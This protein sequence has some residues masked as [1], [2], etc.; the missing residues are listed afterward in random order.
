MPR[1]SSGGAGRRPAVSSLLLALVALAAIPLVALDPRNV[2]RGEP[3]G[4]FVL[5]DIHG[6]RV[7]TSDWEG[8]PAV[9]LYVSPDQR[10]SELAVRELQGQLDRLEA[11]GLGAVILTSEA[12]RLPYFRLLVEKNRISVPVVVDSGREVYGRLGIIV[13][14]TT[15]LVDAAGKLHATLSGHDLGYEQKLGAHMAFLAG[16]IT[17]KQLERDLSMAAPIIDPARERAE[18]FVRSAEIMLERGLAAEAAAALRSAVAADPGHVEARLRLVELLARSGRIDEAE[19]CVGEGREVHPESF[20]VDLGLGVIR[21]HERSMD[22]AE[23]HL[24]IAVKSTVQ[25]PR[26]HYW[27]GRLY[28]ERGEHGRAAQQYR[29]AVEALVPG[30]AG[31]SR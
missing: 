29:A 23:R 19:A 30:I 25:L 24:R 5:E 13:F 3:V 28:E 16:K 2:E 17:A 15:F 9:W 7:S 1:M 20:P 11:A 18:R 10:S 22:Q 26:T 4:E 8:K 21:F 14:P 12:D 31:P 27:L 6:H